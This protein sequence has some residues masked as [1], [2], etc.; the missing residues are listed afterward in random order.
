MARG[1]I[2][3]VL[4][5]GLA[6]LAAGCHRKKTIAIE[7]YSLIEGARPSG[8][9]Q[10]LAYRGQPTV[11]WKPGKP[12]VLPLPKEVVTPILEGPLVAQ[13]QVHPVDQLGKRRTIRVPFVPIA[14]RTRPLPASGLLVL[15]GDDRLILVLLSNKRVMSARDAE[16]MVVPEDDETIHPMPYLGRDAAKLAR[17]QHLDTKLAPT[18]AVIYYPPKDAE[19]AWPVFQLTSSMVVALQKPRLKNGKPVF[20]LSVQET[21]AD[22]KQAIEDLRRSHQP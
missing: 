4:A 12:C 7:P 21:T 19:N 22:T 11:T 15:F 16:E 13:R 18:A 6:L 14:S 1:R 5:L 8:P 20:A 3:A 2:V 10:V 9:V 17:D